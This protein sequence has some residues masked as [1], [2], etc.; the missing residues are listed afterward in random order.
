VV[1]AGRATAIL[2]VLGLAAGPAPQAS[3]LVLP[4]ATVDGPSPAIL[5][6]GGVAM[7]PDG[8]GGLVYTKFADGEAHA[9]VSRYDGERWSAPVQVDVGQPFEAGQPRIAAGEGGRLLV[10]WVTPVGTVHE[11]VQRALYSAELGPGADAFGPP[12]LVDPNV[13][14]GVGASPSLAGAEPGKAIVAYRVVTDDFSSQS[15]DPN[16]QLRPGDVMADVRLARLSGDHWSRLG[17]ANRNSAASM[18]PPSAQN[19]P[20]AA[21]A[22]NGNAVIAWQEPDQTGTARIWV[23][24]VFSATLGPPYEASPTGWEG[25]P[26]AEDADAISLDVTPLG[27]ARIVMRV[28]GGP[29]TALGGTRLFLD[30]LP[31]NA[32]ATKGAPSGP[33][34]IDGGGADPLRGGVGAPSVAAADEGGQSSLRLAFLAGGS[35]RQVALDGAGKPLAV[36]TPLGPPA[37]PGGDPVAA[38]DPGGG[39]LV[40]WPA[41]D[42]Q[43]APALAVRQELGSGAAQ[44]ALVSGALAG[45]VSELSIGRGGDGDALIG[46]REGEPGN[47]EIVGERVGAAPAR[48]S[49]RAPTGWVRPPLAKL[50]WAPARSAVGGLTYSVLLDGRVVRSGLRRLRF[51]PRAALLGSGARAAQVLATDRLGQQLLS[52]RVKLRV[53]ARPPAARLRVRRM[54]RAV[55]IRLDDRQSGLRRRAT[56]V[57]FGDGVRARRGAAFHHVYRRAGRYTIFVHARDRAGNST[58]MRFEVRVG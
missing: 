54:K 34:P 16:V 56:R 4:P 6:F 57:S 7:A 3:A 32:P 27:E 38:V 18:R 41:L 37:T 49:V 9:F 47:Y 50:R 36:P 48:L 14:D 15:F 40:A 13:G 8:T 19:A 11:R 52:R 2:A 51:R 42:R 45:P 30:T 17:V 46:F 55:S 25:K 29:G 21:I 5:D 53:D 10:V 20:Q 39:G 44:T 33:A 58:A 35:V 26:I 24:R 28:G 1:R 22:A 31:Q 23:R 12:L 43:G